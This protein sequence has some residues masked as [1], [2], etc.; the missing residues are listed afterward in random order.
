MTN[1]TL[2][3]CATICTSW[4]QGDIL[5]IFLGMIGLVLIAILIAFVDDLG[6]LYGHTFDEFDE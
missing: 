3:N 4:N 6:W 5:W 2:S 1:D